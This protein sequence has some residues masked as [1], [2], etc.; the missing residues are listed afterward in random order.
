[1]VVMILFQDDSRHTVQ[2][3]FKD[4]HC[5]HFHAD[6]DSKLL[7]V[8]F[9]AAD[10]KPDSRDVRPVFEEHHSVPVQSAPILH[11]LFQELLKARGHGIR[12]FFG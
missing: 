10:P 7:D 12:A 11:Q 9:C 3:F 6:P 5:E 2:S 1:M 8:P 4:H